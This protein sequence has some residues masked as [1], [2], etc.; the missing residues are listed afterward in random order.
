MRLTIISINKQILE[1]INA[2]KENL[3][4]ALKDKS[5]VYRGG[6][7]GWGWGAYSLVLWTNQVLCKKVVI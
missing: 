7:A 1:S 5:P 3:E 6:S 2:L 4:S